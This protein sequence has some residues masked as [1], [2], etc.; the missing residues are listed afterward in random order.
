M[1]PC[2]HSPARGNKVPHPVVIFLALT[3]FVMVMSHVLYMF[4]VSVT[5][6]ALNLQ[7]HTLEPTTVAVRSLLTGD[8]IRFILTS[9]IRNVMTFGPVGALSRFSPAAAA[10]SSWWPTS[11][12]CW[13]S[14]SC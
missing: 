2:R 13:A 11:P 7:T 14:P 5:Y 1:G 8:G 3:A 6:D 12:T 10:A 9:M 4:G